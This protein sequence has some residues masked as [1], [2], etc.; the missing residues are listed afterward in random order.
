MLEPLPES[1]KNEIKKLDQFIHTCEMFS[2][3]NTKDLYKLCNLGTSIEI[4][5]GAL[6]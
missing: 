3:E 5:N 1:T 4:L 6:L 2:A